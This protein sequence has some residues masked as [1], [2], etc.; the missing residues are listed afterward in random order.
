M[1]NRRP[2]LPNIRP[3]EP[4]PRHSV[5]L[6]IHTIRWAARG[7]AQSVG[8]NVS[9]GRVRGSQ[10]ERL[11]NR[12][13]VQ[14]Y[15]DDG[16]PLGFEVCIQITDS[17]ASA[18][19][20]LANYPLDPGSPI[21]R[22]LNLLAIMLGQP[23]SMCRAIWSTDGFR[24]A[25]NTD[26]LFHYRPLFDSLERTDPWATVDNGV[27]KAVASAWQVPKG[28]RLQNAL[29][30]FQQAW[31][32]HETTHACLNLSVVLET[33]CAPHTQAETTHQIAFNAA[34]LIGGDGSRKRANYQ[35]VRKFYGLRSAITHGGAP[36][37]DRLEESTPQ[38]FTVVSDLLRRVL[39]NRP[40]ANTLEDETSRRDLFLSYMFPT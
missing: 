37:F 6:L 16:E 27:C 32:A 14:R 11:Y 5:A 12:L 36:D 15:L 21:A 23:L 28:P 33:L 40:L 26:V 34:H 7:S 39:L 30:F 31:L 10:V 29:L 19:D 38:V 20:T 1:A 2:S 25:G 8:E 18:T 22:S 24:T 3:A 13:S 35:L 4:L 17:G 9:I